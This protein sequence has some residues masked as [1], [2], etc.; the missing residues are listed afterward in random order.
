M[1]YKRYGFVLQPLQIGARS[2]H[3]PGRRNHV[4]QPF[5]ASA[6]VAH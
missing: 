6:R 2:R 5:R 3:R 1:R 4:L